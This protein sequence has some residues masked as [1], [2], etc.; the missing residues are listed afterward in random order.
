ML[1]AVACVRKL[2]VVPAESPLT[3]GPL[4]AVGRAR[5]LVSLVGPGASAWP[6]GAK[7][8]GDDGR[9]AERMLVL[10]DA[11]APDAWTFDDLLDVRAT[12]AERSAF[13]VKAPSAGADERERL[14]AAAALV[15]AVERPRP[16]A[17]ALAV[18]EDCV[19][20]GDA[21]ASL[22]ERTADALSRAGEIGRAFAALAR[23]NGEDAVWRRA[24]LARRRG[25]RE[26]ADALARSLVDGPEAE[27]RWRARA[28][29]A[30]L[31][32]DAGDLGVAEAWL[33]G[34]RGPAAAEV[35]ALVAYRRGDVTEARRAL[36]EAMSSTW[37][38]LARARLEGTLGLVE[39]AAG[40]APESVRAFRGPSILRRSP[41][42]WWRRPYLTG[43]AAA[44]TDDGRRARAGSATRGALVGPL[45]RRR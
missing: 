22:I 24:E 13:P 7:E 36:R 2:R 45:R 42:R 1:E 25:E 37:D 10:A 12:P 27:P 21:P 17:A 19:A 15:A 30:R 31:A 4:S 41:A 35:R 32:W 44:A 14:E 43:L 9:L 6:A 29:L 38:G 26:V 16:D 5:W 40:R 33:A 28:I 39:H 8:L 34:A 11:R 23:A 20:A 3:L 18:A